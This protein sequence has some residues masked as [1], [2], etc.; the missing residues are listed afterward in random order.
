MGGFVSLKSSVACDMSV[1]TQNV[2][3]SQVFFVDGT[4]R[5]SIQYFLVQKVFVQ[6]NRKKEEKKE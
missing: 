3:L 4:R 6:V 2:F 5:K 1:Y